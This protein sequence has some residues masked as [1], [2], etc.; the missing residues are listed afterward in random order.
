MDQQ[1]L[2]GSSQ[3]LGQFAVKNKA[4]AIAKATIDTLL[5]V[6]RT[7]AQLGWPA[8]LVGMAVAAAMGAINVA[9]IAAQPATFQ[10]GTK[11]LDFEEFGP[12]SVNLLHGREAIIPQGQGHMLAR[13]IASAMG[14][15][16]SRQD[17]QIAEQLGML[18][19]TMA[20]LRS[21]P[22]DIQRAVRDGAIFAQ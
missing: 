20:G 9:R 7:F 18:Q 13:E 15:N 3:I 14:G 8:G 12:V 6:Q 5:A 1:A 11:R 17:N 21:L 2:A 4:A 22:R 19:S 16:R 10:E